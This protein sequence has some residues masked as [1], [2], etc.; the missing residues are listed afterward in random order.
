MTSSAAVA[1]SRASSASSRPSAALTS[2][3]AFLRMPIA[4]TT[5]SGIRSPAGS[6]IAKWCRERSVWAPQ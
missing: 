5:S 1:M 4:C 2:A 3:H 6:P